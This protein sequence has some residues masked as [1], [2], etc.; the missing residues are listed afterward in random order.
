MPSETAI[1]KREGERLGR[2]G[3]AERAIALVKAFDGSYKGAI[4]LA[5]RMRAIATAC[6][7]DDYWQEKA[8]EGYR[9]ELCDLRMAGLP[10]VKP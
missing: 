10:E 8:D 9:R 7:Y 4:I 1:L 5:G 6:K 3:L 2:A